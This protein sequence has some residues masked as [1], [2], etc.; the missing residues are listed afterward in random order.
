MSPVSDK[1][2][3]SGISNPSSTG[4]QH[5]NLRPV[6]DLFYAFAISKHSGTGQHRDNVRPYPIN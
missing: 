1:F 6:S 3:T 5:D 4:Q 2:S